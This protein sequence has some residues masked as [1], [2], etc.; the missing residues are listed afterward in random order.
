MSNYKRFHSKSFHNTDYP[1]DQLAKCLPRLKSYVKLNKYNNLSIDFS[2]SDAVLALNE[3]LLKYYYNIKFWSIPKDYLTPPIPGRADYIHY[4]S[5]LVKKDDM[6]KVLDVGVGANLIYPMIGVSVYN[7]D[8]IGSE[9]DKVAFTNAKNIVKNN[10]ILQKKIECRF[11]SNSSD[12]FKGIINKDDF[13]NF[14]MCNPPFHSSKEDA[15]KGSSRKI[16]NLSKGKK[17]DVKLNFG[18]KANELWCDG[19]EL[20]FIVKMIKE[21]KLFSSQVE[22]Y[23]SLVSKKE[24]LDSIYRELKKHKVKDFKTIEMTQGQKITRIVL[25]SFISK[26]PT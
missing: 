20:V 11:Q 2:N 18:G 3:A 4:L 23:T 22:Y 6:C 25:W 10:S 7:W 8:F 19:G 1:F 12:I 21:S 5:D 14:T 16:K 26:I 13:F 15:L 9:I 17:T 24:N